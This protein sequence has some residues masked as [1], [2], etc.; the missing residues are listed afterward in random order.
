MSAYTPVSKAVLRRPPEPAL[1]TAVAVVHEPGAAAAGALAL[2]EK[3]SP[4]S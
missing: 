3:A 1:H 4:L 2:Q